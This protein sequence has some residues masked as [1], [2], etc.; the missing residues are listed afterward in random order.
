MLSSYLRK[1]CR[2]YHAPG[3]ADVLKV[4]KTIESATMVDTVLVGDD[5][6]LLVLLC[7]HTNLDSHKI[8]S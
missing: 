5:T 2:V 7:Y 4:Q 3:D 8:F 6:D 1:K